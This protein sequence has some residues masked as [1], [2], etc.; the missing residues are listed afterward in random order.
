MHRS[1]QVGLLFLLVLTVTSSNFLWA[2]SLSAPP[3]V[4]LVATGGTISN[5]SGGRLTAEELI[6]RIPNLTDYVQPEFEQFAN[7]AS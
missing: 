4:R 5:A 2:Q 1:R 3:R 6:A 7:T